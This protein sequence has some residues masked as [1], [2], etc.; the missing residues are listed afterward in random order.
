MNNEDEIN[1]KYVLLRRQNIMCSSSPV[2]CNPSPCLSTFS[3]FFT[4]HPTPAPYS[5]LES[6]LQWKFF[7]GKTSISGWIKSRGK[8]L[9]W[10]CYCWLFCKTY[11]TLCF[12]IFNANFQQAQDFRAEKYL[13]FWETL[14]I[15]MTK[16]KSWCWKVPRG[17]F[18]LNKKKYSV[19]ILYFKLA[20]MLKS[21][22]LKS[23]QMKSSKL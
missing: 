2:Y 20:F 23:Y 22:S 17:K 6:I 1:C 18:F 12:I 8:R 16:Q 9:H 5:A 4:P 14:I 11:F 3:C 10:R 13:Q 19:K 15:R 7:R 21:V